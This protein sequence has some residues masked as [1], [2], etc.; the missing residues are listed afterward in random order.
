MPAATDRYIVE[1][2]TGRVR[3]TFAVIDTGGAGGARV[4][5]EHVRRDAAERQADRLNAE[6]E[7]SGSRRVDVLE[8][9]APHLI[10]PA[11]Q[12]ESEAHDA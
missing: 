12:A 9:E 6:A 11:T 3:D 8:Q 7:H 1:R 10:A 5:D 2:W 4:V